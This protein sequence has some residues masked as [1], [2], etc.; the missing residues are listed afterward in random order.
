MINTE[1][2]IAIVRLVIPVIIMIGNMAG[3]ALDAG[4]ITNIVMTVATFVA[5][6]WAWWKN[7]NITEAAQTAQEYLNKLKENIKSE[8][9]Q[10]SFVND[11]I[12]QDDDAEI[13]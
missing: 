8:E 6:V 3:Y 12:N 4:L 7:N 5:F 11:V 13:D 10:N 1:R 9:Y 2:L